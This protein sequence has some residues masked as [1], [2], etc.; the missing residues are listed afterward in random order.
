MASFVGQTV[1]PWSE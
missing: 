1:Y